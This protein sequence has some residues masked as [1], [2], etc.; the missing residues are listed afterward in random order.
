MI[1]E[2][3]GSEREMLLVNVKYIHWHAVTENWK[4]EGTNREVINTI[5]V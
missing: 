3:R 2:S 1:S 5:P 4:G